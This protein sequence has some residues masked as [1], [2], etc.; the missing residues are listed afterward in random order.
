MPTQDKPPQRITAWK[1]LKF[2]FGG[3]LVLVLLA[4]TGVI[5]PQP[6]NPN[7]QPSIAYSALQSVG[8]ISEPVSAPAEQRTP[9]TEKPGP[10]VVTMSATTDGQA[11]PL[12]TGT[13]NLPEGTSLMVTVSR[14][15][16]SYA[17]QSKATVTSGTFQAGPFSQGES[18]L[19]PGRY[20]IEIS[21]PIAS[22]QPASVRDFIG[23]KGENLR[24]RLVKASSVGVSGKVVSYSTT[25]T[26]AGGQPDSALDDQARAQSQATRRAAALRDC[27]QLCNLQGQMSLD[28]NVTKTC[29][30]TCG[31]DGASE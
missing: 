7:A 11:K 15:A 25:F 9:P 27:E 1:L 31:D 20:T 13:T 19:N 23:A 14:R 26:I 2:G 16:S 28:I 30:R 4:A 5:K 8:A 17:A 29:L 12:V 22:L 24:G 6:A 18:P 3:Y 10:I 21:T